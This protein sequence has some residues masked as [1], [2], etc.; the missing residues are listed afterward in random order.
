MQ[1]IVIHLTSVGSFS[2][3]VQ[4]RASHLNTDLQHGEKDTRG[5]E[6][7]GS[8]RLVVIEVSV[9]RRAAAAADCQTLQSCS[10]TKRRRIK[11]NFR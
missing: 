11:T 2:T 6:D 7:G 1:V 10:G 3:Q 9:A 4:S 8:C 5:Y